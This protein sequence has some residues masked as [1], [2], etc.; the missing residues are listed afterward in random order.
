MA[1]ASRQQSLKSTATTAWS[2]RPGASRLDG[3]DRHAREADHVQ[4][5]LAAREALRPGVPAEAEHDEPGAPPRPVARWVEATGPIAVS[6]SHSSAPPPGMASC[7]RTRSRTVASGS[8]ENANTCPGI[9]PEH[10]A[11]VWR[12][13]GAG[14]TGSGLGLAIARGIVEAHRGVL[15]V[16]SAPGAGTTFRFTLPAPSRES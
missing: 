16:E 5:R 14:G 7:P 4:P 11:R 8:S 10:L 6:G 12:A 9:A 13:P 3:E 15:E 2:A 1:A